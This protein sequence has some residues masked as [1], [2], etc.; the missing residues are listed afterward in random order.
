MN[1]VSSK[2][3]RNTKW[4]AVTPQ[5]KE[6][7]FLIT[8]VEYDEEGNVIECVLEAVMTKRE[9][10]IDWHDLTDSSIWLQGWKY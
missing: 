9:Q 4:T 1:K 7:H 6:K 3:L 5:N 8:D 10:S 2:K